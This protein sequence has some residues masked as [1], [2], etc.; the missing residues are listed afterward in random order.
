[1]V[2]KE[3]AVKLIYYKETSSLRPPDSSP[4]YYYFAH[5]F[6]QISFLCLSL[7]NSGRLERVSVC[8]KSQCV[9]LVW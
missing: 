6:N 3:L 7:Q 5:N 2:N 1:M 8:Q 9:C 4:S